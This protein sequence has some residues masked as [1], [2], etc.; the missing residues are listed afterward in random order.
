MTTEARPP[1][2]HL[3]A[4]APKMSYRDLNGITDRHSGAFYVTA[5]R[6]GHYLWQRQQAGRALLALTRALYT[7]LPEAD[8]V[9]R[10]WPLPYGA[11]QWILYH[12]PHAGFPGN[13]RVSFQHQATR[14]EGTHRELRRA[15]AWAVWAIIRS[16][17]PELAGDPCQL[18]TEPDN[19]AIE[20]M[21]QQ[22]GH[23]HEAALWKAVLDLSL[24]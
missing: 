21:L 1:C 6:Y 19:E 3:P 8:P 13:P 14:M 16:T 17:R 18:I 12:H 4:P 24:S 7:H 11:F 20:A 5:L 9:F 22:R 15:R 2:P 23:S 10:T